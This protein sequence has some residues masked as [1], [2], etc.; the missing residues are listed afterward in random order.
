MPFQG[1]AKTEFY[2]THEQKGAIMFYL[3]IKNYPFQN[4][5]K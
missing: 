1:V 3:K 5:N 4:G 2:K